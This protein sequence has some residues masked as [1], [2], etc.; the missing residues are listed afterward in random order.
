MQT[1]EIVST[2]GCTLWR[3]TLQCD[4]HYGVMHTMEILSYCVF[5]TPEKFRQ[6]TLQYDAHQSLT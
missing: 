6:L 2:V 4:A 5:L 1:A 3:L